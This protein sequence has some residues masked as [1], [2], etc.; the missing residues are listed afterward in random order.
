MTSITLGHVPAAGARWRLTE[1][2]D[3]VGGPQ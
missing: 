2:V 1:R 3:R